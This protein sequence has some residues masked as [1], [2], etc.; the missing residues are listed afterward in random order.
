MIRVDIHSHIYE[1]RHWAD[2]TVEEIESSYGKTNKCHCPPDEHWEQVAQKVERA[3]VFAMM[4]N[5]AGLVVPNDYVHEYV[6]QH[7]EKLVGVASVD[8]NDPGWYRTVGACGE[9][10][11][12][13]SGQVE[14]RLPGFQPSRSVPRPAISQGP[15]TRHSRFLASEHDSLCDHSLALVETHSPGRGSPTVPQAAADDLPHRAPLAP[16]M[17]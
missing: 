10:F 17:P 1:R 3:A 16:P 12:L 4:M 2:R 7:P 6:R 5:A 15:G 11:R 14:R 9:E 8:P 13:S